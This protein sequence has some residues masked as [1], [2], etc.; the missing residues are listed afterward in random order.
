MILAH[1]DLSGVFLV[2][3][4]MWV[5][6]GALGGAVA[7]KLACRWHNRIGRRRQR[8]AFKDPGFRRSDRDCRGY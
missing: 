8:E 7:V 5:T 4:V 3:W 2:V 6:V 1:G